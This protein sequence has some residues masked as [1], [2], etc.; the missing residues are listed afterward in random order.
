VACSHLL[1]QIVWGH[2]E[3][4]DLVELIGDGGSR[5][6]IFKSGTDGGHMCLGKK[7]GDQRRGTP[8]RWPAQVSTAARNNSNHHQQEYHTPPREESPA[9]IHHLRRS[10][11]R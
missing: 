7:L 3:T 5:P 9:A 6:A 4:G 1:V 8:K 10:N 2:S 11:S